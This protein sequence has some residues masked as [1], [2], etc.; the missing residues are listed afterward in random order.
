MSVS[1]DQKPYFARVQQYRDL[2]MEGMTL[3]AFGKKSLK[4][5]WLLLIDRIRN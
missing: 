3:R 5:S 4:I 1:E 2:L